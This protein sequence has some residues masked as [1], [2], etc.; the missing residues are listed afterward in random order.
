[1]IQNMILTKKRFRSMVEEFVTTHN[2]NYID[3]I[4]RVCEERG[5]EPEDITHLIDAN[6]KER[7]A[8]DAIAANMVSSDI[9]PGNILPIC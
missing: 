1:M 2:M 3:A 5:M 7:I 6:L 8:S 9:R 4:L